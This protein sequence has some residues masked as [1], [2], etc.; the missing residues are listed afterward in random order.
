MAKKLAYIYRAPANQ[1]SWSCSEV[2]RHFRIRKTFLQTLENC[3]LLFVTRADSVE[4]YAAD[5]VDQIHNIIVVGKVFELGPRSF[6]PL[7][8]LIG[9]TVLRL[10]IKD[11]DLFRYSSTEL[12]GSPEAAAEQLAVTLKKIFAYLARMDDD[13]GKR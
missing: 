12:S 7:Y 11:T 4:S 1:R 9:P 2:L 6:R 8:D 5:A 10:P 3:G 13:Y